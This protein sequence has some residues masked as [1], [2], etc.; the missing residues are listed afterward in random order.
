MSRTGKKP[1]PIPDGVEIRLADRNITV[2]GP[3]GELEQSIPEGIRVEQKDG[4]IVVTRESDLK[5]YRAN[6]GLAR[7]LINNMV[8]GVSKRFTK[9]L[10]IVGVGYRA[11]MQGNKLSL[12][13]GYSHPV[14]FEVE[15][16]LVVEVPS[17]NKIVITGINKQQVGNY[18]ATI[19]RVRPPEPY[20]GKG[21]KYENEYI[22]RKVG[23]TGK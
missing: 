3:H 13:V 15:E 1:I 4:E 11:A 22:R 5:K 12:T 18:A 19:R 16:N 2:K 20:K 23:K 8:E 10:E 7:S 21:I 17:N 9:T 14:L 6:H